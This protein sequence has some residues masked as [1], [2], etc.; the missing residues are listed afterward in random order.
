MSESSQSLY[1][2]IEIEYWQYQVSSLCPHRAGRLKYGYV[3]KKR[4]TITCPLHRSSFS[5]ENGEQISGPKCSP[6]K[7]VKKKLPGGA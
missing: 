1:F 2:T 4:K 6:L 5:L 7:V 3:N